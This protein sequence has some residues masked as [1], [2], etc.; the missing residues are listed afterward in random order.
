MTTLDQEIEDEETT[1]E[2]SEVKRIPPTAA[3][4]S[5][6]GPAAGSKFGK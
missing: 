1:E 4:V 2:S 3:K 6:F 5:R